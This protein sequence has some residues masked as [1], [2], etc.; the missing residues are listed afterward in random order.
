LKSPYFQNYDGAFAA[1]SFYRQSV[2]EEVRAF[3][4]GDIEEAGKA[5]LL[6]LFWKEQFY[7]RRQLVRTYRNSQL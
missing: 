5:F 7:I 1:I 3:E 4:K 6:G 2:S